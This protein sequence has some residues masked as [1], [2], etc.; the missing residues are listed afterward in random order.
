[1]RSRERW[2]MK[3]VWVCVAAAAV[4]LGGCDPK[5]SA[6]AGSADAAVDA[7]P[8]FSFD[9]TAKPPETMNEKPC[10]AETH[11]AE[12]VVVD[13]FFV[14][15]N[16]ASMNFQ[17]ATG[18]ITKWKAVQSAMT[19]FVNDAGSAML[20]VGMHYFPYDPPGPGRDW[21]MTS[22]DCGRWGPCVQKKACSGPPGFVTGQQSCVDDSVC[23]PG[24]TCVPHGTCSVSK[25]GCTTVGKPCATD[26]NNV[27]MAAQGRCGGTFVATDRC[28]IASYA[29]PDVPIG[30]LPGN[31]PALIRSMEKRLPDGTTPLGAAL[32][33]AYQHLRSRPELNDPKR[34]SAVVLVSDGLPTECEP[35][36]PQD[37]IK[38]LGDQAN[39]KPSIPTF[40]L[41]VYTDEKRGSAEFIMEEFAKA[42][43][44]GKPFIVSTN[45]DVHKVFL[46]A[47]KQIRGFVLP[48][49][50]L[51][52]KPN[53]GAQIDFSRVNITLASAGGTPTIMPQV[54]NASACSPTRDGWYYDVS[55]RE[56][57]T[58]TT[59]V[60][61]NATC[62]RVKAA[63]LQSKIEL[64]LGCKTVVI[65]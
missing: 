65:E 2:F 40:F 42:G 35:I 8:P 38:L 37:V 16:S 27:C 50:Y 53:G 33:G 63:P 45:Q 34:R 32:A 64:A 23:K 13:L 21:C 19:A 52:P 62:E 58:P 5:I 61:C 26:P 11:A 60:L 48:C 4:S 14:V 47:L 54:A 51:L 7:V 44:T 1:M 36:R 57:Q 20:G 29:A 49:E 9:P 25:E 17:T 22:A 24:S 18:G 46:D 6:V 30:P 3:P 10:A 15:D 31:A 12:P 55:P 39:G 43:R 41:G 56:G 28:D 59:A